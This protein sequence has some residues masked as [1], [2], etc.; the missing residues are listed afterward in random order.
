MPVLKENAFT[1]V[2]HGLPEETFTVAR[3][4]GEEGL[5]T[6]YKFE[7][8][9]VSEQEDVDIAAVL[10]NP[11]TFTIK[12]HFSGDED[13]PFH[14]IIS[15]FEQLHQVD[16]YV[17][18]RAELRPKAW[19][20]TLTHHN[21]VF[22]NKTVSQFLEDLLGDGGLNK[23]LDFELRIKESFPPF[24]YVCQYGESHFDFLSRWTEFAGWYYWFEQGENAEILICSDSLIAHGPLSGRETFT[25]S[26]P[27]GLDAA[28][29]GQVIKAFT[30]KQTPVPRKVMVRDYNYMKPSLEMKGQANVQ[31]KGRGEIYLWGD[32]FRSLEGGDYLARVRAERFLCREKVFHGMSS[33][34][35]VR[36]GYLF[37]LARH[38]RQDFNGQYL[39][40][41][42]RHEG[43]QERWLLGGL[44]VGGMDD[45]NALFYRNT[46]DCIPAGTQFRPAQATA[47][48]R[49]SG[50]VTARIDAAGS[51]QYAELD[52][53]GRYKVVLPFDLSGRE[54]GKASTW[55]RMSSPYA[56]EDYGMHFPLHKGT[57]V[58]LSFE[59][60]DI[61]RPIIV[62]A[63]HNAEKPNLI[64]SGTEAINAIRTAAGNHIAMGDEKGKEFINLVCPEQDSRI[65]IGSNSGGPGGLILSTS[66]GYY[67]HVKGDKLE[68]CIGSTNAVHIGQ[69]SETTLGASAEVIMGN[70][71][72]FRLGGTNSF[73]FGAGI[74]LKKEF[75][76]LT[77]ERTHMLGYEGVTIGG[78]ADLGMKSLLKSWWA[79]ALNIA[80]ANAANAI[81]AQFLNPAVTNFDTKLIM[82]IDTILYNALWGFGISKHLSFQ[83][84]K[85][86]ATP[87]AG[88]INID[89]KGVE[90]K[91]N[92]TVAKDAKL[93]LKVGTPE[94]ASGL[95]ITP[96]GEQITL[97]NKKNVSI[98]LDD[99]KTFQVKKTSVEGDATISIDA[100]NQI[101]LVHPKKPTIRLDD[102]GTTMKGSNE[103]YVRVDDEKVQIK[104]VSESLI[105]NKSSGIFLK[106]SKFN[107]NAI[108]QMTL[109][110]GMIKLG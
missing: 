39:T 46:F 36:P 65:S 56:G 8:L 89:K 50:T 9:L 7:I 37:T 51:G 55:L 98:T 38:Y 26:P 70:R 109:D 59:E 101:S 97:R 100:N 77:K 110:G 34:P 79:T 54:G 80:A 28:Q 41:M 71:V 29:A 83:S 75:L 60:G 73:D 104:A 12:E 91:V 90:I 11:A 69:S 18:Y 10:Q 107:A 76:Q 57:E 105:V 66:E 16:Q 1:F 43:S 27:S 42:V 3:F 96:K 47:K 82:N 32:H 13:L 33:I 103:P 44:E 45:T 63:V 31:D 20:L 72:E 58:L 4:S 52:G 102:V 93:I 14:G 6:L 85:I 23:G 25:Y 62:G 61:D 35:A 88:T 95:L 68:W 48:P 2:S 5:S 53:H 86:T 81:K 74:D 22:L 84:K 40:T 92:N 19:W 30:L 17:F 108:G 21:Q 87:M 106:S 94:Q 49:I 67:E 24:D 99:G 78:G 64:T 15:S